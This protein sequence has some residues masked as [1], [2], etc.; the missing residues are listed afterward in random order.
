MVQT[1]FWADS[2]QFLPYRITEGL[3]V[4]RPVT[5][6]ISAVDLALLSPDGGIRWNIKMSV[7]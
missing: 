2:W 3:P 6:S 7:T 5:L 1:E 4:T